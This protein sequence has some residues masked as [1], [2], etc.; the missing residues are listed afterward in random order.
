[1]SD[2]FRDNVLAIMAR[3]ETEIVYEDSRD[4]VSGELR[5][6]RSIK[7]PLKSRAGEKQILVIAL[8]LIH[9]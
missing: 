6:F 9:I 4:A 5:H 2:S 8:S 3:G 7:K 1:M